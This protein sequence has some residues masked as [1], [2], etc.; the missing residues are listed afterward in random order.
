MRESSIIAGFKQVDKLIERYS[1]IEFELNRSNMVINALVHLLITKPVPIIKY[2]WLEKLLKPVMST[3]K[4]IDLP[5]IQKIINDQTKI[6]EE[7]YK[8]LVSAK[9]KM[10]KIQKL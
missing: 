9:K 4:F 1:R 7:E 8:K 2:K 6:Q 3:K 10:P 5:Q